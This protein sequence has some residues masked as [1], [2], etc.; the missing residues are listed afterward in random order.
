[1]VGVISEAGFRDRGRGRVRSRS[2]GKDSGS[3][4]GRVSARPLVVF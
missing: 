2:K 4:R 1:M 3:D